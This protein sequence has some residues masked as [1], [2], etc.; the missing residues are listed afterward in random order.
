MAQF[1]F[2]QSLRNHMAIRCSSSGNIRTYFYWVKYFIRLSDKK[3]THPCPDDAERWLTHLAPKRR[4]SKATQ[5][6]A[7]NSVV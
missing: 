5:A 6:L 7:P 2:V 4:V 1:P 3:N